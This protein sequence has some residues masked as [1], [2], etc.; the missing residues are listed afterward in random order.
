VVGI[1]T[2]ARFRDGLRSKRVARMIENF[3]SSQG[4]SAA[5][6]SHLAV[7]KIILLASDPE[8]IDREF[9]ELSDLARGVD[10]AASR[11]TR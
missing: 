9:L 5:E 1:T 6:V 4:V 7:V 11:P 10:A 8:L 3:A 2:A